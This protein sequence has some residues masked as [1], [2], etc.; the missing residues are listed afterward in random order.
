[1]SR[2]DSQ[3]DVFF[4]VKKESHNYYFTSDMFDAVSKCMLLTYSFIISTLLS[5]CSIV[6]SAIILSQYESVGTWLIE[7]SFRYDKA[8]TFESG[9]NDCLNKSITKD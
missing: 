8:E 2:F 6:S 4:K 5:Y 3:S 1:M 7:I 9:S